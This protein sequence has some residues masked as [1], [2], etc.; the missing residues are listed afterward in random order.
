[1][2]ALAISACDPVE[3]PPPPDCGTVPGPPENA[4]TVQCEAVWECRWL[5]ERG[6]LI[7]DVV[8]FR[9]ERYVCEGEAKHDLQ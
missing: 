3:Q 5:D 4:V 2:L 6:M 8:R 9:D 1:M 7:D